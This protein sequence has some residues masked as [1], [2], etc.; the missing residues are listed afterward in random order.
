MSDGDRNSNTPSSAVRADF[1]S[2]ASCCGCASDLAAIV[3]WL[4]PLFKSIELPGGWKVEF[5]ELKRE[6]AQKGQEVAALTGRVKQLESRAFTGKATLAFQETVREKLGALHAY[7]EGIGAN[8]LHS[9]PPSVHVDESASQLGYYV[10]TEH[11]IVIGTQATEK[12][13]LVLRQYSFHMLASLSPNP[14]AEPNRY[15]NSALATY[16]PCSLNNSPSLGLT[17]QEAAEQEQKTGK[18]YLHN[19]DHQRPFSKDQFRRISKLRNLRSKSGLSPASGEAPYGKFEM[20]S[21]RRSPTEPSWPRGCR[22]SGTP[23]IP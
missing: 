17:P 5:Q 22:Q 10:Q 19:L 8:L 14:N 6:V 18:P 3:P 4:S 15:I 12:I 9:E 13:D 16:F 2:G 7:F 21:D 11:R 23:T 1:R 20:H